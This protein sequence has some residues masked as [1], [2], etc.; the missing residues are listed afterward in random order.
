[1]AA[2]TATPA[3]RQTFCLRLKIPAI[4]KSFPGRTLVSGSILTAAR[5]GS[6]ENLR[7]IGT[8]GCIW[9][10]RPAVISQKTF[11]LESWRH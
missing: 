9:K 10:N 8:I 3:H 11:V 2:I 5:H 1:M 7:G 6:N 4:F